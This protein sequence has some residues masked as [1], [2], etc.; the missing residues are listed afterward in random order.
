MQE[1]L[2]T[3]AGTREF[4]EVQTLFNTDWVWAEPARFAA[5][6]FA[7][8]DTP[9]YIFHYGYVPANRREQMPYGAGHGAEIAYVF[10]NLNSRRGAAETTTTDEEVASILNT[11]WVNFAKTGNPNGDGLPVWPGYDTE[12]E[13]I[14]DIQPDG[15]IVGKSDTRKQRL[16]VIEKATECRIRIQSRGGI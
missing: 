15:Q 4:A 13:E 7:A 9:V 5:R 8:N 6:I 1:Q 10:H 16:D 3:R 2:L 14:L 12:K 11:Y